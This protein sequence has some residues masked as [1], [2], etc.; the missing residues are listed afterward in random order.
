[1]QISTLP[2]LYSK[3]SGDLREFLHFK[4]SLIL[5]KKLKVL[6]KEICSMQIFSFS[7]SEVF[8]GSFLKSYQGLFLVFETVPLCFRAIDESH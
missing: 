4:M 6:L 8:I 5:T 2:L 3:C 7:H 1:M